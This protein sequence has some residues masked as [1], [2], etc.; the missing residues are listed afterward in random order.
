M[1]R[2]QES[3]AGSAAHLAGAATCAALALLSCTALARLSL[4]LLRSKVP[5]FVKQD[6]PVATSRRRL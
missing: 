2:R 4:P 3:K 1:R 5:A 6:T